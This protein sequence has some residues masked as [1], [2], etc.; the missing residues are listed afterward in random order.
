MTD[1]IKLISQT[2][3]LDDYGNE[4]ATEAEKTVLCEV[5]SISQS[6]FY[7]AANTELNPEYKFTVFFGDYSGEHLL[8]FNEVR[9]YIY[10]TYRSGDYMELYAERKAGVNEVQ[11]EGQTGTA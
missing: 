10:R 7:A 6:E 3:T 5:D 11:N 2:I 1:V 8:T 9:Y 4:V